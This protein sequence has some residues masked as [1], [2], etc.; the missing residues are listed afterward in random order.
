MLV[1]S[2]NAM[3][4]H[5]QVCHAF[6]LHFVR[7]LQTK[8]KIMSKKYEILAPRIQVLFC[9]PSCV[10][11]TNCSLDRALFICIKFLYMDLK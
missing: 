7:T 9:L 6:V 1:S 2:S 5:T 4:S 10:L 8:A 11:T 3:L